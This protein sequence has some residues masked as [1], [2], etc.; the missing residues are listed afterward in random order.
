MH[1][2]LAMYQALLRDCSEEQRGLILGGNLARL[3]KLYL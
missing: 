1:V 2:Q 3:L